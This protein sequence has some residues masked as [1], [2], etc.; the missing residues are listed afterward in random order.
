MANLFAL[1]VGINEYQHDGQGNVPNLTGCIN[2]INHLQ[3]Y[4]EEKFPK[5]QRHIKALKN[6]SATYDNVVKYFGPAHL[7]K[8]E[9][10]DVVLFAYSG[11]GSREKAAPEF[12]KYFPEGMMETLVLSDSRMPGNYDL[13]DKELAV[14][15]ERIA[16]KGAHVAVI[17]DCCHSGSGTRDL[18]DFKLG[19]ARQASDRTNPRALGEYLNGHFAQNPDDFYL[20]ASRHILLAACDRREKAYETKNSRGLFSTLLMSVLNEPHFEKGISYTQLFTECRVRSGR[21]ADNQH[22]QFETYGYFNGLQGFL[23]LG[24]PAP[25]TPVKVFF[26]DDQWNVLMGAVS[27]LPTTKNRPATFEISK[28]GKVLGNARTLM[29]GVDESSI[30]LEFQANANEEYDARL[31][32]TPEPPLDFYLNALADK[33]A[34]VLAALKKFQPLY[35][36]LQPD[37]ANAPYALEMGDNEL[38]LVRS[39]DQVCLR[40][41]Q[42][43]DWEAMYKDAFEKLDLVARWEKTL[44]LDNLDT[45]LMQRTDDPSKPLKKD[46]QL[47]LSELDENGKLLFQHTGEAAIV[48]VLM[49]N[50]KEVKVPFKLEIRNNASNKRYCALMYGPDNY[51]LINAGFNEEIPAQSTAVAM[52]FDQNGNRETLGLDGKPE[53]VFT[54]KL[55]VSNRPIHPELLEQRK[56]FKLFETVFFWKTRDVNR[57]DIRLAGKKGISSLS[58][59]TTPEQEDL[60]DWYAVNM[61]V[62]CVARAPNVGEKEL[63]LANGFIKIKEHPSFRAGVNLSAVH[64]GGR[65]IEPMSVVADLAKYEG[66]EMLSFGESTRGAAAPNTIELTDFTN[67]ASLAEQ[68]LQIE[69][70]ADLKENEESEDLLLPLTFDGEFLLPIGE[71]ERSAD[72]SAIVSI[73]KLPDT[74]ETRRKSIGKALKLCF[75][76]L[77]LKKEKVQTL[78]WVDYSGAKAKRQTKGL[79][80]EVKKA[81]NIVLV[82]HGI[83]GD[84]IGMAECMR[85]AVELGHADLI[86]TFDYENLN[87]LIQDTA[88][89][90]GE[91]LQE[92]AGITPESGKKITILAHSMGG[93]VS[94]YFIQ[95]L[96]GDQV[97]KHLIMAG[98]PNAGSAIARVTT[99]RDNAIPLLTLLVNLPF[100]LPAAATVL[101]ILKKSQV[102]TPTLAQMDYDNDHFLKNLNKGSLK[103]LRC[104]IVAG[105]LDKYLAENAD[106]R[107]LMDR[108]FNL[109]GRLFYG[110]ETPNDVAVSVKSIKKLPKKTKAVKVNVNSHHLCY[111]DEPGS[112][113]VLMKLLK[114]PASA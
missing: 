73:S 106:R 3:A 81:N 110:K 22:P 7:E 13:G 26:K 67:E 66:A 24:N 63:P 79:K 74:V 57:G 93:L 109:G 43:D 78:S 20:P 42:G 85:Q 8:A 36:A 14:L 111:F 71:V 35:F 107:K 2:D 33:Q 58:E 89:R 82:I 29:V 75:L 68:P 112:V 96:G 77:V 100:G 101:G 86:L 65:G 25:E 46:V 53:D 84:T 39:A 9:E 52:E 94:R 61:R 30:Q 11:H 38:R 90:L 17:L 69:I 95:N 1:L 10:G 41:M 103:G 72:G 32:S 4:L 5:N 40:T 37:L 6:A 48:D 64:S 76:K 70:A 34:E 114:E 44:Q 102:I 45:R 91:M 80:T 55:F 60:H 83:I 104:S 23:G 18:N 108:I 19:T 21:V 47:I 62:R 51:T 27:G 54:L 98:T 16:K 59:K 15:I 56:S 105:Y 87:T 97:V 92:E 88:G 99:Y 12:S 31:T 50:S 28:N 113:E 49:E